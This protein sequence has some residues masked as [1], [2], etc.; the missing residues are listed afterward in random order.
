MSKISFPI[1]KQNTDESETLDR[2]Y[3]VSKITVEKD[4]TAHSVTVV[5]NG[6]GFYY[7]DATLSGRYSVLLDGS[8]QDELKDIYFALED[9]L[10]ESNVD[11]TSI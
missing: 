6:D 7:F 2:D 9:T 4:G 11:V 5:N 10:T 8:E 3:D 1:Y